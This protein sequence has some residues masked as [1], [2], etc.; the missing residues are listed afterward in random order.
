MHISSFNA[1]KVGRKWRKG[2]LNYCCYFA[3]HKHQLWKQ[4]RHPNSFPQDDQYLQPHQTEQISV[5]SHS[6]PQDSFLELVLESWD[7]SVHPPLEQNPPQ[8]VL[9]HM[10]NFMIFDYKS[11]LE[12]I[13]VIPYL[14]GMW[15]LLLAFSIF[16][17]LL[18]QLGNKSPHSAGSMEI[19]QWNHL[20]ELKVN[21]QHDPHYCKEL[22]INHSHV[23]LK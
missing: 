16:T 13:D 23:F 3:T 10:F 12:K 7:K 2:L 11:L 8:R 4:T 22:G 6:C 9:I 19:S 5:S 14:G 15:E 18:R 20:Q 1:A 17:F 21:P